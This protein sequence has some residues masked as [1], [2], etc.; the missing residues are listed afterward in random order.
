MGGEYSQLSH[1]RKLL[2]AEI[3]SNSPASDNGLFSFISSTT[4]HVRKVDI[5]KSG[6][7]IGMFINLCR[8]D[9]HK[10]EDVFGVN[11]PRLRKLK[12]KYDP[13]KIW[14]KGCVIEPDFS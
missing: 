4:E 8:G 7:D 11:L 9:E 10:V 1:R 6:R 3:R 5:E 2:I 14:S 12:A 13:K